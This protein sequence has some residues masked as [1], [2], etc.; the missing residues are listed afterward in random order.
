MIRW[1]LV[2]LGLTLRL[3]SAR[4]AP[5]DGLWLDAGG[6]A[7][8]EVR[9]AGHQLPLN[10]SFGRWNAGFVLDGTPTEGVAVRVL[11]DEGAESLAVRMADRTNDLSVVPG[12][13]PPPGRVL[14]TPQLRVSSEMTL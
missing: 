6:A 14:V 3:T 7:V 9:V 12:A 8:R 2:L 5:A 1:L 4:G 11:V 13:N 10:G